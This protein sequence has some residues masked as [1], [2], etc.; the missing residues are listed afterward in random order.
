MK[1]KMLILDI[2]DTLV[3][4]GGGISKRNA[5]AIQRAREAGV[6]VTLATGRGYYGS[7]HVFRELGLDTYVINYAGAVINDTKTD[8][9]IF[10]TELE[11]AY[12]QEI[13]A[14]ADEMNLHAHLYQ[15]DRIIYERAH[16]YASKYCAAL[17]LPFSI[18]PD[19]RKRAWTNVPKV[20]IITEPER[21]AELLP[22]FKKH[23]ENRVEVSASSPGFIEFNRLG[24]NKGTAAELLAARLGIKREETAAAGDNTLDLELIRWAGLGAVVADGNPAVKSEADVVIPACG[25]DGV[26]YLIENY[27]LKD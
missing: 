26:A 23:F 12:V 20:L 15:G 11:N 2:D 6:Y 27:V 8:K 1:Y 25:E 22:F 17:N 21:V 10:V 4:R 9:P 13:L 7:S 16:P 18:D 19:I 24:A 3:P 14:M 5:E